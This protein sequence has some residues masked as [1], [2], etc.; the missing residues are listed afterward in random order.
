[1]ADREFVEQQAESFIES[2]RNSNVAFLGRKP[3]YSIIFELYSL[4][5]FSFNWSCG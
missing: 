3:Y 4:V 5:K 1:M 2:A